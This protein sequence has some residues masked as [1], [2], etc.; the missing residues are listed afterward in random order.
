MKLDNLI[1]QGFRLYCKMY[2]SDKY[3]QGIDIDFPSKDEEFAMPGVY[4]LVNAKEEILK[5]G[6]SINL[7]NR[8]N[9]MYKCISNTTN[10]KIRNHIKDVEILWVY[11]LPMQELKSNYHNAHA[12][13]ELTTSYAPSLEKLL[14]KEYKTING[15]VPLLNSGLA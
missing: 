5:I 8:F 11:A 4:L 6:Q 15:K 14:L 7:Y 9:R 3:T 1:E 12:T 2:P 10:N 13:W